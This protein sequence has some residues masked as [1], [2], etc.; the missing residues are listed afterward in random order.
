MDYL[1]IS[2]DYHKLTESYKKVEERLS[3]NNPLIIEVLAALT[4]WPRGLIDSGSE[5]KIDGSSLNFSRVP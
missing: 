5:G 4:G 2:Y 1:N 3:A